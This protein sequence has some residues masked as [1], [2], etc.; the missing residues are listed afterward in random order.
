MN[1][2]SSFLVIVNILL[3]VATLC[4]FGRSVIRH[5]VDPDRGMTVVATPLPLLR[6]DN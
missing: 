5:D 6:E 1:D 3:V 4:I 2:T